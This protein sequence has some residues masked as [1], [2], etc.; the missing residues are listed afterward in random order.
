MCRLSPVLLALAALVASGSLVPGQEGDAKPPAGDADGEN[1]SVLFDGT[2]L[3]NW[4]E[5]NF[6][7]GAA[8]EIEDGAMVL[9][10]GNNLTGVTL[11][12]EPA[13]TLP[14]TDYVIELD[15]RRVTGSDFFCGLT[16]PVP[17]HPDGADSPAE[18]SHATVI[19]GGWGGGL[20]GISSIDGFDASKNASTTFRRFENGRWY[21]LRV[22]VT[23]RS[24]AATLDGEPLF[25]VDIDGKTVSMRSETNPSRPLGI[26]TFLTTGAVKDVR[27]RPL[28]EDE[29]AAT[30]AAVT[31]IE[32][33]GEAGGPAE[34]PG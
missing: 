20:V 32:T 28:N 12:G 17:S 19:L 10:F 22:A 11:A 33:R 8:V 13:K 18:A 15:A 34:L 5:T 21:R 4:E 25:A 2:S 3:E 7:G 9:P 26:A 14:K 23:D 1:W 27:V 16:L 31:R 6:G 24:V 29:V 30:D